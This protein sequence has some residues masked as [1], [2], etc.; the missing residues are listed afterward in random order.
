M[1]LYIPKNIKTGVPYVSQFVKL[2]EE[3]SKSPLDSEQLEITE[4]DP[5]RKFIALQYPFPDPTVPDDWDETDAQNFKEYVKE[6]MVNYYSNNFYYVK[7]TMKVIEL[8]GEYK[9]LGDNAEISYNGRTLRIRFTEKWKMENYDLFMSS[10]KEFLERLLY[11]EV[12]EISIDT[13]TIPIK[14]QAERG[15]IGTAGKYYQI[16][17]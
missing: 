9:L 17:L 3:Y 10:L 13:L 5:V 2:L 6:T 15:S 16:E 7:G 8:I 14:Y 12:L 1:N 11:Y 4:I